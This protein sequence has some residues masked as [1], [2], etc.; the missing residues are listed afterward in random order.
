M[1]RFIGLVVVLASCIA[2]GGVEDVV[3][4]AGVSNQFYP[5]AVSAT[6]ITGRFKACLGETSGFRS[7]SDQYMF[8][9]CRADAD[10]AFLLTSGKSDERLSVLNK[11]V[12]SCWLLATGR[13]RH[14]YK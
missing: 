9:N 8:C 12:D 11:N 2:I 7:A 4:R 13:S 10:V 1:R 3:A 5:V 14:T 6:Y